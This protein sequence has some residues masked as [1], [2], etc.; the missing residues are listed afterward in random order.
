M[1]KSVASTPQNVTPRM[2]RTKV[3][4]RYAGMSAWKIKKLIHEGKL[5]IFVDGDRSPWLVDRHD[6]DAYIESNKIT[7]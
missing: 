4:A 1:T 3:A 2:M 7:Y 6:L 5:R